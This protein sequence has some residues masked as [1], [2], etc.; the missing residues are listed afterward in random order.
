MSVKFPIV[1]DCPRVCSVQLFS[2]AMEHVSESLQSGEAGQEACTVTPLPGMRPQTAEASVSLEAG[3]S[4]ET[5]ET[6]E[7]SV[8]LETMHF[9]KQVCL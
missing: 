7:A 5:H 2:L 1:H 8:S 3:V 4:L 9:E 6:A